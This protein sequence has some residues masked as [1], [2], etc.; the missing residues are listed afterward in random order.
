MTTRFWQVWL[1]HTLL[2]ENNAVRD[3]THSKYRRYLPKP[4][5][6][7]LRWI[8]L[9][10]CLAIAPSRAVS[11]QANPYNSHPF[12]LVI[13]VDVSGSSNKLVIQAANLAV[14]FLQ[15][16][17]AGHEESRA[18][19]IPFAQQP[20]ENAVLSPL[21]A[22]QKLPVD[23]S[24]GG[25]TE[26]LL[27]IDTA[28]SLLSQADNSGRNIILVVTDGEPDIRGQ[29][30]TS[31]S[32]QGY[33]NDVL[34]PRIRDLSCSP[35]EIVQDC[36]EFLV[37]GVRMRSSYQQFWQSTLALFSPSNQF[38]G[39]SNGSDLLDL[40]ERMKLIS[41]P[42]LMFSYKLEGSRTQPIVVPANSFILIFP[43]SNESTSVTLTTYDS[44]PPLQ[45]TLNEDDTPY[46]ISRLSE[47]TWGLKVNGPG[48]IRMFYGPA[49]SPTPVPSQTPT[50]THTPS[51]TSTATE[52][53][54]PTASSTVTIPPVATA[55]ATPTVTPTPTPDWGFRI[56]EIRLTPPEPRNNQNI[57]I[58]VVVDHPP[59][60][61]VQYGVVR[62]RNSEGKE[63]D[64]LSLQEED[65]RWSLDTKLSCDS[66]FLESECD[67]QLDVV[68]RG[69]GYNQSDN[70]QEQVRVRRSRQQDLALGMI[71]SLLLLAGI[72]AITYI[73]ANR[74]RLWELT[75]IERIAISTYKVPFLKE[76]SSR[77][78]DEKY[79]ERIERA[80]KGKEVLFPTD[81]GPLELNL[82]A[83]K[84]RDAVSLGQKV[85]I[86]YIAEGNS[87]DAKDWI[88][89]RAESKLMIDRMVL[90]HNLAYLL[91]K[92]GG[93]FLEEFFVD[94]KVRLGQFEFEQMRGIVETL[95]EKHE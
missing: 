45:G 35:G 61:N 76:W 8:L 1:M 53:A 72:S 39:V 54:T 23:Y 52:T 19:I 88:W 94:N 91:V 92:K 20:I 64:T 77:V 27:A 25:P 63:I 18:A 60:T 22:L 68:V 84:V 2:E 13:L 24:L 21:S 37:A 71:I 73:V 44:Q 28:W 79:K 32:R 30:D 78:L 10:A 70:A 50:L 41:G 55:T 33:L 80:E 57:K 6:I 34:S 74:Q 62:I 11:A 59:G 90:A 5:Q 36:V 15:I 58:F 46:F 87:R 65:N 83:P 17:L 43:S 14:D 48:G 66:S 82:N 3:I 47:G 9:S 51:P 40:Y 31:Q 26:F 81:G 56:R 75:L 42:L 49:L 95:E 85:F 67:Y 93:A 69:T 7:I 86:T 4:L 16:A 38:I 29:G 12:N 89:K